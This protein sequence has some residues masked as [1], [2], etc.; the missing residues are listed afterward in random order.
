MEGATS[1]VLDVV[2]VGTYWDGILNWAQC[3][4]N[5]KQNFKYFNFQIQN[6]NKTEFCYDSFI[7]YPIVYCV[8]NTLCVHWL[9]VSHVRRYTSWLVA[10]VEQVP[11]ALSMYAMALKLVLGFCHQSNLCNARCDFDGADHRAQWKISLGSFH[12]SVHTSLRPSACHL[13]I[14]GMFII[15]SSFFHCWFVIHSSFVI[16]HH[17]SIVFLLVFC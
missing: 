3:L 11:L 9:F 4:L 1:A 16:V 15:C 12:T 14:V 13:I 8:C 7:T 10:D 17:L 6:S 2:Q 5:G